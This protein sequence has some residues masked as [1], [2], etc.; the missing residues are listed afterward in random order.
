[1]EID[2]LRQALKDFENPA[3]SS[4]TM[5]LGAVPAAWTD[6]RTL[7]ER[8]LAA[9]T[10]AIGGITNWPPA[11]VVDRIV[12]RGTATLFPWSGGETQATL[13]VTAWFTVDAAGAPQLRLEAVASGEAWTLAASLQGL[14]QTSVAAVTWEEAAFLLAS[15]PTSDVRYPAPV[16]PGVNLSGTVALAGPF[17]L[18]GALLAGAGART[19]AGHIDL[20]EGPM[21][22]LKLD[23]A[24]TQPTDVGELGLDLGARLQ[25]LYK[26]FPEEP[27]PWPVDEVAVL[28]YLRLRGEPLRLRMPLLADGGTLL[29]EL[30]GDPVELAGLGELSALA[31]GALPPAIPAEV[32]APSGLRLV[33][34]SMQVDLGDGTQAPS[35]GSISF[36]VALRTGGWPILPAGIL[37]VE[38]LGLRARV[39]FGLGGGADALGELYGQ[40]TLAREMRLQA[41]IEMPSL[42][43]T[44]ALVPGTAVEVAD[45][46][47]QF[48]QGLT[49]RAFRPPVEGMSI[50]ALDIVV[51]PRTGRF[52][53][54]GTVET[55]WE[56]S[57]GSAPSGGSLLTLGLDS[58]SLSIDYEGS[59]LGGELEAVTHI[60]EA[61]LWLSASTPGGEDAGWDVGA[62]L[63]RGERIK[64]LALVQSFLFPSGWSPARDYGMPTLDISA[65]EL[66][67]SLDPENEPYEFTAMGAVEAG[68]SFKV[69]EAQQLSLTMTAEAAIKGKRAL[70]QHRG[71]AAEQWTLEGNFRGIVSLFGL[72]LEAS[73]AFKP[74]NEALGFGVWWAQRGLEATITRETVTMEKEPVVRTLLSVR[75]GDLSL[76][77][78]LEYLVGLA[79]PGETRRLS[80]PWDVLYQ[81]NFRDLSLTVDLDS[82]DVSVDYEL[83]LQL[84]F[85]SIEK[86]GLLYTTAGGEGQVLLQLTGDF[87]GQPYGTDATSEP[88]SWDVVGE[89]AP[90]VPGKGT[91]LLDVR[92]VGLGQRIA[93][94]VPDSQLRTVEQ[95]LAAMR[96]ALKPVPAGGNP[97]DAPGAA[98]MR[99]D[100]GTSW[101]FGVDATLLQ[102][103]SL[104]AVFYDPHLYGALIE[105]EGERAG[106]LAGLRVELVYRRITDQIGEFSVD[107]RVPDAF[108][109]WEFGEVSITLGLIHVDIYTNGNFRVDAGFPTGGDFTR[110]FAVQVF[111]FIGQ[112]GVY[113]ALLTG[114]TSERVPPILNGT[115]DPVIEA[116]VGLAVGVGKEIQKGPLSAGLALEI[117][118]IFEGVYAPFHPYDAALAKD[119]YFWFQGT[120]GIVGKLYGSVDFVIV[121]A[122]LSI[123]AHAQA[124]LTIEAHRPSQVELTLTVTARASVEVLFVTVNFSFDLKLD[125]GFSFGN[126]TPTPWV[127][128]ATPH[129]PTLTRAPAP[130]LHGLSP[131]HTPALRQQR[132]QARRPQ[133]L[134]A[135]R[136][137]ARDAPAPKTPA[138][139]KPVALYPEPHAPHPE[140]RTAHLQF[141]PALTVAQAAGATANETQIVLML[142]TEN[143]IAPTARSPREVSAV[144]R[145]HLH[146][147]ATNGDAAFAVVIETFLRWA[148][149][150][151]AGAAG[152]EPIEAAQ[153]ASIVKTLHEPEFVAQTFA[154]ENLR[155][156]LRESLHMQVVGCPPD[157]ASVLPTSATFMAMIPELLAKVTQGGAPVE[158]NYMTASPASAAYA[159]NL[160]A[161]FE[162]LATDALADAADDPLAPKPSPSTTD[163]RGVEQDDPAESS[164]AQLVFG[165]YMAL[166][167]RAS[168]QAAADLLAAFPVTYPATN[169]PS[170]RELAQKFQ[171][172][173]RTVPLARGQTLAG[174]AAELGLEH[175]ALLELHPE[176]LATG[177]DTVEVP[178]AVTPQSVAR[179]NQTVSLA[180]VAFNMTGLP[181]QVR[182]A[183][184]RVAQTLTE[185]AQAPPQQTQSAEHGV[186]GPLTAEA[187]GAANAVS[188][189]LLRAGA[190]LTIP[191]YSYTRLPGD[192]D[193]FL[194]AFFQ[195]RNEGAKDVADVDWWSQAIA[196]LNPEPIDWSGWGTATIKV[197]TALHDSTSPATY[198]IHEG[199]TLER[200]A[201]TLALAGG[202]GGVAPPSPYPVAQTPHPIGS[203]D[204]F[205]S[206]T[207]DF[208]DLEQKALIAANVAADVLSPLE[209]LTLPEF[210]VAVQAGQT[211][212]LLAGLFDLTIEELATLMQATPALFVANAQLLVRDVPAASVDALVEHIASGAAGNVIAAQ[213]SRLLLHGLRVPSPQDTDFTDLSPEQ[214]RAGEFTGE[215]YG[216]FEAAGMQ[217][218]WSSPATQPAE[219]E[220][221]T[222]ADWVTLTAPTVAAGRVL[223]AETRQSISVTL[224][225]ATFHEWMPSTTLE[226]GATAA[227]LA[228][229][230]SNPLHFDLPATIHWQATQ[231]PDLG[232]QSTGGEPH[233]GSLTPGPATAQGPG[234][235]SL[236]PFPATLL[237]AARAGASLTAARELTMPAPTPAFALRKLALDA[238]PGGEGKDLEEWTWAAHVEIAIRRVPTAPAPGS[239]RAAGWLAQSYAVDGADQAGQDVLYELWTYLAE[240]AAKGEPETGTQLHLLRA[241]DATG[242]SPRG[243]V[244]DTPDP[245]GVYLLKTNLST[246][247]RPPSGRAATHANTGTPSE[248]FSAD[249]EESQAF[250]TFLWEASTVRAGGF[251]LHYASDGEGL[252]DC[253]F[254]DSGRATLT[255]VCLLGSQIGQV[256]ERGLLPFNTCG[257]VAENV[258]AAASQLYA[259][260]IGGTPPRRVAATLPPGN[261]GFQ[262]TR[263]NPEAQA[264]PPPTPGG[265]DPPASTPAEERTQR[266]YNLFG[267]AASA[268][269]GF[270]TSNAGLPVGPTHSTATTWTYQHVF[271][272]AALAEAAGRVSQHC[273]ALPSPQRDPYA[274]VS[275]TAAATVVLAAQ[276]AFGNRAQASGAPGPLPLPVRYTDPLIGVGEWPGVSL[277][278][279]VL[280]PATAGAAPQLQIALALQLASCLP[281]PGV[282]TAVALPAASAFALR[283]ERVL[284]Q[285]GRPGVKFAASTT[286]APASA[287]TPLALSGARLQGFAIGAYVLT[288]QLAGLTP[289][290]HKTETS[291]TL[292][293]LTTAYSVTAEDLLSANGA[294]DVG[295]LFAGEVVVAV[296]ERVKQREPIA[297][298]ANRVS[299]PATTLL[300]SYENGQSA[301]AEGTS[302]RIAARKLAVDPA[303]T[304]A[305]S[306]AAAS[307]TVADLATANASTANLLAVGM[308]WSLR[309]ITVL[310]TGT[311]FAQLVEDFAGAGVHTNPAEI[312]VAN[313]QLPSVLAAGTPPAEFTVSNLLLTQ[314]TTVA[315]LSAAHFAS[316]A[317][318]V[319]LNGTLPGI[320]QQ[321]APLQLELLTRTAPTGVGV[322]DYV[323]RVLGLSLAQFAKANTVATSGGPQIPPLSAGVELM[324]PALLDPAALTATPYG[325]ASGQ[326]LQ[327]I[328]TLHGVQPDALGE[329]NQDIRGI[330]LPGA[331]IVVGTRPAQTANAEDSLASLRERFP[332]AERPTLTELIEALAAQTDVLRQ[333]AAL[334]CPPPQVP[335]TATTLKQ[336]AQ[337][338]ELTDAVALGRCNAALDGFLD[339]TKTLT[340]K[341]ASEAVG[342]HGT[343]TSLYRRLVPGGDPDFDYFLAAIEE[344]DLLYVGAH[345]LTPA[346]PATASAELP[347]APAV[348]TTIT[349]LG[350]TLS[351]T[352]P[353]GEI[354]AELGSDSDVATRV[355]PVAA[356]TTGQPASY[357]DFAHSLQQAWAGQLRVAVGKPDASED[358][359]GRARLYTVRFQAPSTTPPANAIRRI[360]VGGT[361]AY[362]ALAPLCRELVSRTVKVRTYSSG[363]EEPL[364]GPGEDRA[365]RAIDV[366]SWAANALEAI[367]L[368]LSA[369]YA[370]G[371][372]ELT[373]TGT[374]ASVPFD[375]IVT[376]K[377]ALAQKVAAGLNGVL[378][379]T[380]G[381]PAAARETLR[382]TLDVSLIE[383]WNVAALAQLPTT[384]AA[385]FAGSELDAGGHRLAGR[386]LLPATPLDHTS[387]LQALANGF[388]VHV[389]ALADA[390]GGTPNLLKGGV[391][392]QHGALTWTIGEHD[393]LQYG[394]AQLGLELAAFAGEFATQ[395]PLFRDGASVTLSDLSATVADHD[396]LEA[397][398]D[399]LATGVQA[400]A[401]AN[402]LVAGLLSGVVYVGGKSHEVTP[403]TSSLA[404]MASALGLSIA[405]LAL[406]ISGQTALAAGK[407]LHVVNL[408][409]E[410]TLSAG[411]VGLDAS[412]GTLQ[413]MLTL[414]DP[415][416][417][418]RL[419]LHLKLRPLGLEYAVAPAPLTEGYESS[420][421]LTFLTPL[422]GTDA[423]QPA[424]IDTD[425]GQL[426]VPVP[427][428]AYPKPPRLVG[429]NAEHA[430]PEHP[431]PTASGAEPGAVPATPA[432]ELQEAK[433]WRYTATFETEAA[434]QDTVWLKLGFNYKPASDAQLATSAPDPFATLAELTTNLPAIQADLLELLRS[435]AE[436]ADDEEARKRGRSGVLALAELAEKL[437]STWGPI[438][439]QPP[440]QA[441]TPP[442]LVPERELTFA[443][444]THTRPARD[445]RALISALVLK[446]AT[447]TAAWGPEGLEP[448]LGYVNDSGELELLL[449]ELHPPQANELV[450]MPPE[451]IEVQAFV[452]RVFA[453]RYD[454]MNALIT[455]NAR[456][457]LWVTRNDRL[458]PNTAT[459]PVFVYRTP[460]THFAEICSPALVRDRPIVFGQGPLSGLEGALSTLF[461]E[462]LGANPATAQVRLKLTLRQG[463]QLVAGDQEEPGIEMLSP[464]AF[465]PLFTYDGEVPGEIVEALQAASA[466]AT[467]VAALVS[468][469]VMVFSGLI[470]ETQPLLDLVRL[471]Y[472]LSG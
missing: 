423:E 429:Q 379:G 442:P 225:D 451:N 300:S 374:G 126:W 52:Q 236:W 183:Q 314:P 13:A 138:S 92:Y 347:T 117:Y 425:I 12:Y 258:D 48:M 327:G 20:G 463:F 294:L 170:L 36:D 319:E 409:P 326:S 42:E 277:S 349:P 245:G 123:E 2:A 299:V 194:A 167:T 467:G 197:P 293:T 17:A 438:S 461:E 341:G 301:I 278:Y 405:A 437:A 416:R 386:A 288:S 208:P 120:V 198:T 295:A 232:G 209:V 414:A 446:R 377:R 104:K 191:A 37:T 219:V 190:T 378:E 154:Y 447:G 86:I 26:R 233:P 96:D 32:P 31:G 169:G 261:V 309:E 289:I 322:R 110:S 353:A 256:P 203:S 56:I 62:G 217:F 368:V 384:V 214:V 410:V 389:A 94:P 422:D 400:L 290:S 220:L 33:G 175:D 321:G 25:T 30:D 139:W 339:H 296:F 178:V 430:T 8:A 420:D 303:L 91:G 239:E 134:R 81:V 121:K 304:L 264:P 360:E 5:A 143:A 348:N 316:L 418:R 332:A 57:F 359:P 15:A 186:L 146:R 215:L 413:L 330:F 137:A 456:A 187:V 112:G 357:D 342:A 270:K 235:P 163:R 397:L 156:L 153:L 391:T 160:S 318:F 411:K 145:E 27:A 89:P 361:P 449:P 329:A 128:A 46:L 267:F 216:I 247:T 259:V 401:I 212:E 306:A 45:L 133:P 311:T 310:A 204:T 148:A 424:T 99:Y 435:P 223:A 273:P 269:G 248:T 140:P 440:L 443:F 61:H 95:T 38:E 285:I 49:G 315:A 376:A 441:S 84:G 464:V 71:Q 93:L 184:T 444:E 206:L 346:P 281:G 362:F 196:T 136:I 189:G 174:L 188:P 412:A 199:D 433:R 158:R 40:V 263:T 68:W 325:V 308:Q 201:A 141:L 450:Y 106:S 150:E 157:S 371:A 142:S 41:G 34:L 275:E 144:A 97:L 230:A 351:V 241:P 185:V 22:V 365:F 109:N 19:V 452:R 372:F 224:S 254:D 102:T 78:I 82:Y 59:V 297:A 108:R 390:L 421:W 47:E 24:L 453:I 237:A 381:D 53:L 265:Q 124:V 345:V 29:M 331:Q 324:L 73:Y 280:A 328:A 152:A 333:G 221:A 313:A 218:P 166:L 253:V 286:L 460:E 115:F 101:L 404:G 164:L 388:S 205:K 159:A 439:P 222:E 355:S 305:Q 127:A 207:S 114:A 282:P 462:L 192:T 131:Q 468:L 335:A 181:Y 394:A 323:E 161:Y 180:A 383:G 307:C 151:G 173:T 320:L 396:T 251:F 125:A 436:L 147:P 23:P 434:A 458:V 358:T 399:R 130:L 393:T 283:Y 427:L 43:T 179:D 260:Q 90:A 172:V 445:G 63:L 364:P 66:G 428:R 408:P 3:R 352:R 459:N 279:M 366:Q 226:L 28:A 122:S 168:V 402:Q 70:D 162:Q 472:E 195:V 60:G 51:S 284:W 415:A 302:V 382:Q 129:P 354:A 244:S 135:L 87:L 266:L 7:L 287:T 272:V 213:V 455:Q 177:R 6:I 231:P 132:S 255:L 171:S 83:K 249:L 210:G 257:V 72:L 432:D 4:F 1:M 370:A 50:V 343:L 291:E 35:R 240:R 21:P 398:A 75:F 234:E 103:L 39:D 417:W 419:P 69:F 14:A 116:G 76:G 337:A 119:T 250:L 200:V 18:A 227:A 312:A 392:L 243:L 80:A 202:P 274:G 385:S 268:G 387:T 469:E 457:A 276:D 105:L 58:V 11:T 336:L 79:V 338:L 363:A 113:L 98:G 298:F 182:A 426:E 367:D 54:A 228:L 88:L 431:V 375:E 193:A 470:P 373:R 407:M 465:R 380:A 77:E 395:A 238:A 111:P 334:V 242:A 403:A 466:L 350:T 44:V 155:G 454:G 165:E 118:G 262:I 317:E 64:V 100:A 406:A 74:D 356:R 16:A 271:E 369:P 149:L 471:V 9:Q 292:A 252:P 229:L 246:E 107:L 67:V 10:L 85:A 176:G 65:L 55:D 448:R 340:F 344:A 211:L